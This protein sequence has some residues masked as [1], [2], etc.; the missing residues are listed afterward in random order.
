MWKP[1]IHIF[2]ISKLTIIEFIFSKPFPNKC[3]RFRF[4]IKKVIINKQ[5]IIK[6]KNGRTLSKHNSK[7]H[8]PKFINKKKYI[9][10]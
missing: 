9:K 3:E 8:K 1:E 7:R 4:L 10:R 2:E 6:S 5:Y